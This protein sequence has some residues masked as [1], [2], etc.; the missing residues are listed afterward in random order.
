METNIQI[1]VNKSKKLKLFKNTCGDCGYSYTI[2]SPSINLNWR[3]CT[4]C[5]NKEVRVKHILI[6]PRPRLDWIK[7]VKVYTGSV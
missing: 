4:E 2:F 3:F 1:K 6:N 7:D 5:E